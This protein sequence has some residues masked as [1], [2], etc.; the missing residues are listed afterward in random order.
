[1]ALDDAFVV[2]KDDRGQV[3]IAVVGPLGAGVTTSLRFL[4]FEQVNAPRDLPMQTSRMLEDWMLP[5]SIPN[6]SVRML[7]RY[8]GSLDGIEISPA[9]QQTAAQTIVL[10]HLKHPAWPEPKADVNLIADLRPV[11]SGK[12]DGDTD[13]SEPEKAENP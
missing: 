13:A 11:L 3:R 6:G 10:A 9:T 7:A 5:G 2:E 1:M 4:P 8:D 12:S